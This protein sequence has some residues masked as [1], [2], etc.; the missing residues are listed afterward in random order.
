MLT[1]TED[2]PPTGGFTPP[3]IV[4]PVML[5][6]TEDVPPTGGSTPSG[7]VQP[8]MLS[9]TEDVPP[10]GGPMPSGIVNKLLLRKRGQGHA[11]PPVQLPPVVSEVAS[12]TSSSEPVTAVVTPFVKVSPEFQVFSGPAP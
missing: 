10:T 11:V 9:Q 1:Q 3:G 7:V 5:P 4:Q 2:V 8:V 12:V 6:Q